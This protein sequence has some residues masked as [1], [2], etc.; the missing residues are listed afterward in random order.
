MYRR[1]MAPVTKHKLN[2]LAFL[3]LDSDIDVN[4]IVHL[5]VGADKRGCLKAF[6]RHCCKFSEI[7]VNVTDLS[8]IPSE[9]PKIQ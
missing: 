3:T 5:I 1:P 9:P 7:Q 2:D 4:T 6:A 8:A